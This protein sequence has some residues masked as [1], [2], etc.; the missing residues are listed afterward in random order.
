MSSFQ[1]IQSDI[2][3]S[4]SQLPHPIYAIAKHIPRLSELSWFGCNDELSEASISAECITDI[5]ANNFNQ[6][7][8]QI[9]DL[10]GTINDLLDENKALKVQMS[11]KIEESIS[12]L[13][14][15]CKM[16]ID[17]QTSLNEKRAMADEVDKLRAQ[18]AGRPLG[19]LETTQ[20]G[21]IISKLLSRS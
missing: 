1:Q 4:Q 11:T 21:I 20:K 13:Q 15:I 3:A 9:E 8:Q 6:M 12:L 7:H 14:K 17:I 2:H 5:L 10:Q 18:I 16:N 19:M